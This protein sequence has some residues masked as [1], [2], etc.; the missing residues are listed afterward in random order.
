MG[1]YT[2]RRDLPDYK[3]GDKWLGAE[4]AS[5][6]VCLGGDSSP[7]LP[8]GT[9]DRVRA[10]FVLDGATYKLDSNPNVTRDGA[11]VIDDVGTWE[12]TMSESSAFLPT[13]G[14]WIYDVEYYTIGATAPLTLYQGSITVHADVTVGTLPTPS[15]VTTRTTEDGT[16]RTTED[17]TERTTED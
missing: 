3:R 7:A 9:L 6:L 11:I 16:T 13:A 15:G 17:G 1:D 4:F 14:I 2:L 10:H 12:I 5:P 8:S